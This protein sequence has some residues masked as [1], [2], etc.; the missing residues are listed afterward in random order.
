MSSVKQKGLLTESSDISDPAVSD[1]V[2][3]NTVPGDFPTCSESEDVNQL[4]NMEEG[5]YTDTFIISLRKFK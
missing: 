1:T 3:E 4:I 5:K 2:L